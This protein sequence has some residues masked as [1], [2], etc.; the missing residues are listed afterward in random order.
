MMIRSGAVQISTSS[1]VEWLPLGIVDRLPS[2]EA[3]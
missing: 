1:W 2:F 3:R